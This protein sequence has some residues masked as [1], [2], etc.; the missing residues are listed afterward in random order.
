MS[1]TTPNFMGMAM[2]AFGAGDM[3]AAGHYL[4]EAAKRD[5]DNPQILNGLAAVHYRL[6]DAEGA[7][8]H[9]SRAV[10]LAPGSWPL[11]EQ[12][13]EILI[14]LGRHAE[15]VQC[16]ARAAAALPP[17]PELFNYW[18]K[19]LNETGDF[20]LALDKFQ[21]G[22][23]Q[24]PE[25]T[26]TL[27]NMS[28]TLLRLGRLEES[29]EAFSAST[30]APQAPA[31]DHPSVA[32]R[33]MHLA[34]DYDTNAL[35]QHAVSTMS[36]LIA[37]AC[38]EGGPRRLLDCGC[39]TGLLGTVMRDRVDRLVGIDLS[40]AMIERARAR[41]VYDALEVGDMVAG[42]DALDETFD[43]VVCN[44]A[45]YHLADL[46]PFF[47]AAA[48]LLDAGGKL[49]ISCDP[50]IDEHDIRQSAPNEYTHSR[51]YLARTAAGVGLAAETM[52]I[53]AHRAYPG[54]WCVF[55]KP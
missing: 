52:R 23:D 42:M 13:I 27:R 25:S 16:C 19:S 54:F 43:A 39:G 46:G 50:C 49:A 55:A 14:S 26:H 51:A 37:N 11:W 48:R 3:R 53:M 9:I 35:H 41:G 33:Y 2:N 38:T 24:A 10:T 44:F 17:P 20:E 31:A 47:R 5:P 29:V 8:R 7:L 12:F 36:D 30:E 32:D 1:D 45:I 18:G 34:G 22:L 4:T 15:A 6:G 40:G 21:C 28:I